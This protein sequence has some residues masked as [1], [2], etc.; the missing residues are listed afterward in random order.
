M[1]IDPDPEP[2]VLVH[3]HTD[4]LGASMRHLGLLQLGKVLYPQQFKDIDVQQHVKDNFV[5]WLGVPYKG[6]WFASAQD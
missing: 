1:K 5:K 3:F 6:I 4:F 2:S